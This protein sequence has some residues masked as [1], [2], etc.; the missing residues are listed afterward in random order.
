MPLAIARSIMRFAPTT[1][2]TAASACSRQLQ[3]FAARRLAST[4]TKSATAA[5][6]TASATAK[7]AQDGLSQAMAKAGPVFE[8]AVA[9]VRK[10]G[11]PAGKVV[12]AVEKAIPPTVRVTKTAFEVSKIVAKERNFAPPP[13]STFSAYY[14]PLLNSVKNPAAASHCL[15]TTVL[16]PSTYLN[17]LAAARSMT[18]AQWAS[19]AVV[20]VEVLGFFTVGEMIG[21]RKIV[22]YRGD[23]AGEH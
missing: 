16:N 9:S 8:N 21:R 11:G 15:Q 4:E 19:A 3:R 14:Q 7:K 23:V 17:A 13:L 6:A 20:A 22:G 10:L 18:R 12:A 1:S 5:S 2:S